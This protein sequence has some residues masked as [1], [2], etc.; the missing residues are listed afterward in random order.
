MRGCVSVGVWMVVSLCGCVNVYVCWR[1][2]SYMCCCCVVPV[3]FDYVR[4]WGIG[5][6]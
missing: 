2:C 3:V 1:V 5:I 4:V 6:V